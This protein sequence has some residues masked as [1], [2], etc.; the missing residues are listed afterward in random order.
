MS[1]LKI[2]NGNSWESIPA[3]GV[4]VPSGGTTGQVLKK[5]SNTDYATEWADPIMYGL[6]TGTP[7]DVTVA[8]PFQSGGIIH[9]IKSGKLVRCYSDYDGAVYSQTASA[10]IVIGQIPTGFR[11][12]KTQ[13]TEAIGRSGYALQANAVF[14]FIGENATSGHSY[15]DIE[16]NPNTGS[17]CNWFF[18][19]IWYADE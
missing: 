14:T 1:Q 17:N 9:F 13:Y 19:T 7:T 3:G 18:D 8:T 5:S 6:F 16:F 10:N 2:K 4:G 15:G 11:P 12:K